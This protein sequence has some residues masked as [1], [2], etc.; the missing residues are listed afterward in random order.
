[1]IAIA[2]PKA[3]IP[4]HDQH[5]FNQPSYFGRSFHCMREVTFV[6]LCGHTMDDTYEYEEFF[7]ELSGNDFVKLVERDALPAWASPELLFQHSTANGVV[8]PVTRKITW[9]RP[10][11]S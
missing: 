1:M 4:T 2:V 5:T 6:D 7:I 8:D 3:L 9:I 10:K 11:H